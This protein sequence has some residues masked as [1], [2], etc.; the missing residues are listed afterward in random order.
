MRH[1]IC[2]VLRLQLTVLHVVY[3]HGA[4]STSALQSQGE[5]VKGNK[6]IQNQRSFDA[7]ILLLM[8]SSK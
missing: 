8:L 6:S 7:I 2:I 4:V 1:S 3:S 5:G